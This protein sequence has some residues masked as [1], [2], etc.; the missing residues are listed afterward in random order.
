MKRI[1]VAF[2]MGLLVFGACSQADYM[3]AQN[4]A[5][6]ERLIE[7]VWNNANIDMIDETVSTDFVRHNPN[8]WDPPMIEGADAFKA[9][10]QGVHDRFADFHVHVDAILAEGD[11]VAIAW[12]V[13]GKSNES[14][15][16]FK[17]RGAGITKYLDGKAVEEWANWDTHDAMEQIGMLEAAGDGME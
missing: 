13:T 6:A 4:K 7:E 10:V 2:A 8:S 1:A 14:G 17:V 12:T 11:M 3:A 9:Y 15:R 5:T 16:D